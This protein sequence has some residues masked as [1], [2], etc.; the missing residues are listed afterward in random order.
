[1]PLGELGCE[2][3]SVTNLEPLASLPLK[4]LDITACRSLKDL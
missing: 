3:T 2:M 4:V 1:M